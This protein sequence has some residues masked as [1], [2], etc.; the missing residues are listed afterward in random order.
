[1]QVTATV[2]G[3][4]SRD[5]NQSEP[6]YRYFL[7]PLPVRM[8]ILEQYSIRFRRKMLRVFTFNKAARRCAGTPGLCLVC[9]S[10]TLRVSECL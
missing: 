3:L 5:L 10:Q 6:K 7:R 4:L 2:D 8:G 9:A 1:M